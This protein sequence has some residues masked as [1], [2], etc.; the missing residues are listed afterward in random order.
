MLRY[1]ITDRHTAGGTEALLAA[2]AR[3]LH[4]GVER[5]QIREKDLPCRE[6]VEL[7]RRALALPN[8]RGTRFLV[9]SRTD[10]VLACGAHGVHM[11]GDSIS[12]GILRPIVPEGF[13]IGVSTHTVAELEAAERDG[14]D[15]AVFGP[16][17]ATPSKAAYG[18]PQGLDLLAR[19]ARAVKIPV[20]ALGG[21]TR[22]NTG[23]CV[24]A[25]AAG[26]AGVSLFQAIPYNEL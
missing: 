1:Y 8:P 21:I 23:A 15:F 18:L 20:L 22:E 14:A 9:N 19:A 17:F 25:G 16:V 13:L 7:V 6:L 11:P 10:V 5:I 26:I 12:P 3:A 2:I 24:A 4:A